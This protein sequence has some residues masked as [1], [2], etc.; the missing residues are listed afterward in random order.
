MGFHKSTA[1]QWVRG[2]RPPARLLPLIANTLTLKVSVTEL[3]ENLWGEKDRD[4]CPCGRC[5]GYKSFEHTPPEARRLWIVIPCAKCGT[6]R[7][8]NLGRKI[9][10]ASSARRVR[11]RLNGW[12]LSALATAITTRSAVPRVVPEA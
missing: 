1:H 5:G 3:L 11:V 12:N 8:A 10:I 4:D 7:M 2:H 9:A 6:I